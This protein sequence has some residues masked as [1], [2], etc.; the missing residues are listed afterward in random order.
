MTSW[1]T[2]MSLPVCLYCC[3]SCGD[4]CQCKM[5]RQ[6]KQKK[7]EV[8]VTYMLWSVIGVREVM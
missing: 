7:K 5:S 2:V 4:C 8:Q 1:L 3:C 6:K